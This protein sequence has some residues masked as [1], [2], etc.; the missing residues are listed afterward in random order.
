MLPV[1]S[2][3]NTRELKESL[4]QQNPTVAELIIEDTMTSTLS[5][6][7]T[8]ILFCLLELLVDLLMYLSRIVMQYT[9]LYNANNAAISQNLKH[10]IN[11]GSFK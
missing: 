2:P 5:Y 9:Y 11:Q 3:G 7:S 10:E 1:S 8:S 6:T 4:T